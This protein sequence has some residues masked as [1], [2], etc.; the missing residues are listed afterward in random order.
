MTMFYQSEYA[1]V[2]V[3]TTH[4]KTRTV[5]RLELPGAQGSAKVWQRRDFSA[6]ANLG[7]SRATISHVRSSAQS[8]TD[9]SAQM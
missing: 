3:T 6:Y 4:V 1:N 8:M 2:N 7:S 5:S 9:A